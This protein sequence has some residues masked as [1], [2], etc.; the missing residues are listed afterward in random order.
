MFNRT[1]E[2]GTVGAKNQ[3]TGKTNSTTGRKQMV[4][5]T[6]QAEKTKTPALYTEN[7]D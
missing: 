7:F 2:T 3:T 5:R 1:I 6:N 4:G